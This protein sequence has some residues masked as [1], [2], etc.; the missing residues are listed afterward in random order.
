MIHTTYITRE[1]IQNYLE[2]EF[3]SPNN[4]EMGDIK[5]NKKFGC[6]EVRYKVN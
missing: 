5:W 1:D 4:I 2:A 3:E 6:L